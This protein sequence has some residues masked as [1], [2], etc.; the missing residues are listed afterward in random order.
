MLKDKLQAD[1]KSALLSGDKER[2][3]IL[4]TLKGA[5]LNEEI[6]SGVREAGLDDEAMVTLMAKES[7][8]RLEAADMYANAGAQDKA[9]RE[10]REKAIIEEYLPEQ[11]SEADIIAVIQKLADAAG[12]V[13]PQT[14]GR[15][16]GQANQ[17][18]KGRADGATIAGLV[19]K[20][21]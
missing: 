15:I 21:L 9:D 10:L 6:A 13:T 5:I 16:I 4:R 14:M 8:K 18:L 19:K 3:E 1:L 11:A 17:E 20:M 12:G 2:A 7:K